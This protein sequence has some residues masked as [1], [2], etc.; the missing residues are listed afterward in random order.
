MIYLV[1]D[2]A[3]VREALAMLLSTYG[4][5]VVTFPDAAHLM[6]HA[7]WTK[8]AVLILD[9]RLPA[10]SGL[11]LMTQLSAKGIF[12]PTIMIT[13]HGDVAACRR[14]F[15]AGVIDFLTKPV[16]EHVLV[17]AVAACEMQLAEHLACA[18][19]AELF[20]QL[21]GR[22]VEVIGLVSK[23]LGSK[24]IAAALGVSV[25]TVDSHRANIAA[26]LGTPSVAEQTTLWLSM[27]R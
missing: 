24:E 15:R 17:E 7:D 27:H 6:A 8:P 5:E 21:T 13:G 18:E 2:D 4:K 10:V 19:T 16:D 9:L 12:W 14:A 11:Q 3:A 23:G 25:R 22:E 26:K 20:K 1:D